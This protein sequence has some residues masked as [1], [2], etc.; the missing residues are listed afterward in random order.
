MHPDLFKIIKESDYNAIFALVEQ[1]RKQM[2]RSSKAG[3]HIAAQISFNQGFDI[4]NAAIDTHTPSWGLL[5]LRYQMIT[6]GK[7]NRAIDSRIHKIDRD[8]PLK[9]IQAAEQLS[10]NNRTILT[11][12]I[13]ELLNK[14]LTEE[15]KQKI[16]QVM[17]IIKP[18][19]EDYVR[20]GYAFNE[21]GMPLEAR[22]LFNAALD[23]TPHF[24]RA[25]TALDR[26]NRKHPD[27]PAPDRKDWRQV[28]YRLVEFRDGPN[29]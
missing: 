20:I 7:K 18:N 4:I 11:R 22:A 3:Q 1:H 28:I 12:L 5:M 27:L 8:Q 9:D 24:Q 29:R 10:P 21:L 13:D 25:Q 16:V 15:A 6:D 14:K 26:I 2:V 17:G 19:T 23:L